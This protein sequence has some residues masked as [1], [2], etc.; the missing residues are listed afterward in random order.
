MADRGYNISAAQARRIALAAQGFMDPAPSGRVTARHFQR[1]VERTGLVQ[2][3]SVNVLV[4]AHYM[5]FFSRLGPYDRAAL[6]RYT[7]GSGRM[8]EYWGH[9][10][11][12]LPLERYPLFRHR[13]E[14]GR[15]NR[16]QWHHEYFNR[17]RDYVEQ[18]LE[19]IREHGPVVVGDVNEDGHQQG[20]WNWSDAKVALEA[21]FA[22]GRVTVM[23]RRNFSRLYDLPERA[24]PPEVLEAPY[25]DEEAAHRELLTLAARHHGIGTARDL[26]DYYRVPVPSSKQRLAEL[27]DAGTLQRVRVEGWRE[28]AYL[29]PDARIPRRVEAR[30]LLSPFDPV[31]W[32]RARTE[33]LFNFHYRIEIYVPEPKR[34]Y[35]Y[36]VLPFL[37]GDVLVARVDLKADR[38]SGRLLVR[39]AYAEDGQ[40]TGAVAEALAV[41]LASMAEWLGLDQVIV[42]PKGDLAVALGVAVKHGGGRIKRTTEAEPV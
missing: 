2:I 30:A 12:L 25:P 8:W 22:R 11:S 6:D 29:H 33:R 14:N 39:G 35:G 17:R 23:Q 26:A 31:V 7:W 41:E 1:V 28:P 4:R 32:E 9:E 40:D 10:A 19:H 36:Y 24:L 18:V 16:W 34:Q 15:S 42:E 20:W 37:L 5:P 13:M 21:L 27:V 38:Q 3:D